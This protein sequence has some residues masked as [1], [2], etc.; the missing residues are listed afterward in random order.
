[1]VK[2]YVEGGGDS[3]TLHDELRRGFSKLL[4][5]AGLKGKMPQ[6]VACGGRSQTFDRFRTAIN[7]GQTAILL[8]DSEDFV[9]TISPWDHL[10]NRPGDA[11][12]KP[13]KA[14]DADCFFMVCCMES[15]FL[16]DVNALK[17]FLG[18]GFNTNALPSTSNEIEH[19]EKTKVYESLKK[20]TSGCKTKA[21][22]GKG[23]HSFK[24]LGLIDPEKVKEA[25]SWAMRFFEKLEK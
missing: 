17:E 21:P 5:K 24:I 8:V 20:A 4:E 13:E 23:A 9:R 25:S 19:I 16:A 7:Q 2:L 14:T 22:Y 15:W 11:W 3:K 12:E 10:K 1:M 6:I 18:Q